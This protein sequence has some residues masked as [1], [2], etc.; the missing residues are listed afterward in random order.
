[1]D[2]V[3]HMKDLTTRYM[4]Q[5]DICREPCSAWEIHPRSCSLVGYCF[6]PVV[7]ISRALGP[8][9]LARVSPTSASLS[10]PVGRRQTEH[11]FEPACLFGP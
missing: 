9:V 2:T 4:S 1:M 11:P 3:N 10:L 7:L 8:D 5:Y 6:W